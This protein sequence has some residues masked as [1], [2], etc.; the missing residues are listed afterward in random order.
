MLND[1]SNNYTMLH[2]GS[3]ANTESASKI[4]IAQV[5]E[6][7]L[8]HNLHHIHHHRHC[9]PSAKYKR[10]FLIIVGLSNL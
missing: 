10:E 5:A 9:F 1:I 8:P 2:Y 4:Y 7:F 6:T 3:T